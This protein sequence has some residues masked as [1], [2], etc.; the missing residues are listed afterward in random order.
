M[1]MLLIIALLLIKPIM[2]V[3]APVLAFL[4]YVFGL[5]YSGQTSIVPLV[6]QCGI[7]YALKGNHIY[8]F[9]AVDCY[10]QHSRW[11]L[12]GLGMTPLK[13]VGSVFLQIGIFGLQSHFLQVFYMFVLV[14]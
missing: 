1:P 4:G 5:T 14:Y 8:I 12:Q 6:W 11:Y 13:L 9:N 7:L 2:I 10:L 3:L